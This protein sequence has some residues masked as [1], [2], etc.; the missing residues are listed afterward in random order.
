MDWSPYLIRASFREG[1]GPRRKKQGPGSDQMIDAV[2]AEFFATEAGEG[3]G[4]AK[5][6]QGETK[7]L[8]AGEAAALVALLQDLGLNK[9][10]RLFLE[11]GD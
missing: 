9:Y 11:A 2:T 8:D 1:K 10:A 3:G 5:A 6:R 4:G 7:G